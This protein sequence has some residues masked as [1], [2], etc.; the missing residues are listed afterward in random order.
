MGE[1]LEFLEEVLVMM[2][3]MG[4]LSS[5]GMNEEERLAD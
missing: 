4:V 3:E 2:G 5:G 1:P